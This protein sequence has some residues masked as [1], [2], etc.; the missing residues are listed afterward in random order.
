[1]RLARKPIQNA[2]DIVGTCVGVYSQQDYLNQTMVFIRRG[3]PLFGACL[4]A[5]MASASAARADEQQV[6]ACIKQYT[7]MGISAAAALSIGATPRAAGLKETSGRN[8]RM[9]C[10]YSGALQAPK[11][12]GPRGGRSK[13]APAQSVSPGADGE[14]IQGLKPADPLGTLPWR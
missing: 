1:M 9:C 6:F 10:I 2:K 7:A 4:L 12:L 14:S 8:K 11:Q 3:Y 5:L 13:P